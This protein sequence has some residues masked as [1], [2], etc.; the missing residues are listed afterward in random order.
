MLLRWV[1]HSFDRKGSK[2]NTHTLMLYLGIIVSL[3]GI[4]IWAYD[5]NSNTVYIVGMMILIAS[6]VMQYIYNAH[7]K[8][9]ERLMK[10]E[11]SRE[12]R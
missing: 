11:A 6:V 9:M 8:I 7:V 5:D 10:D 1:Y 12:E 3:S 2:M 4:I